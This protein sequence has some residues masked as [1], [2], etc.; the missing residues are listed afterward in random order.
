MELK[1]PLY[2]IH[3]EEG[4]RIV[5][6]AGY[7]LPVQYGTGVVAEHMAVRQKAGLFDVSHMG[8]IAFKGPT[9]LASL[10]HILTNSFSNMKSGRVRY[11]VMCNEN[12]GCVDDVL[13][14]KFADDDWLVVVNASNRGK[15]FVHMAQ[16]ALP[17]TQ[18]T[19]I[20]DSVAQIALQGPAS[21]A[22]MEK[23]A[24]GDS[25]PQ[26]YYTARR[27]VD[28]LGMDCLVSRTGYTGEDGFE[29]YTASENAVSMWK[30]LREAGEA[31]GVI[32]CGLGARDTLRLE[33]AM[34][35]YGHEIDEDISPLEA[36]FGFAV[37]LAKDGFI[38]R[39]ALLRA[40][41]P[42]RARVGLEVTGRGII[43]E[44]QDV[45]AGGEKIGATT[46]GTHCP[47][48]GKGAAMA[49]LKKEYA[50]VG[51]CVEADVRG[52]RVAARVVPL[53]FYS[54]QDR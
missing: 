2:G 48:L 45:Y 5:P 41:E 11:S 38:G 46:S 52:R 10:E 51:T 21:A 26:K 6:F 29:I 30:A 49:L 37:K 36:G 34:P 40:G 8:E 9:A 18:V 3:E 33:A 15:D 4:G 1:T 44:H 42:G 32:P 24:D 22:V 23:L 47:Y 7:L 53:P 50:A 31:Y 54:R 35:L 20:S 25:L 28:I 27:H 13:V 16:N 43:R 17:G 39:E 14:Y 19:D 12:G